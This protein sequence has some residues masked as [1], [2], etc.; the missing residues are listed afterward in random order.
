MVY[1]T[2]AISAYVAGADNP[3]K[4]ISEP[5]LGTT[6]FIIRCEDIEN[7]VWC[8]VSTPDD[9]SDCNAVWIEDAKELGLPVD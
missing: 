5:S 4:I 8:Y 9:Y 7:G 3:V 2:L 6:D 1:D